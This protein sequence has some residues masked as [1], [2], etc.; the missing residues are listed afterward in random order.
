[1]I[2]MRRRPEVVTAVKW[3][4]DP[5]DPGKN[6]FAEVKRFCGDRVRLETFQGLVMNNFGLDFA[7]NTSRDYRIANGHWITKHADGMLMEYSES[8]LNAIFEPVEEKDPTPWCHQCN[9][10][11]QAKC[12]C[13]PIA[14]NN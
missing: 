9:A 1:M 6:N 5:T 7:K 13:G 11:S 12:E 3:Q 10:M 2:T 8:I 14:K 4:F